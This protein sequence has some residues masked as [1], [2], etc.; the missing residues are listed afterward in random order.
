MMLVQAIYYS[1]RDINRRSSP[2]IFKTLKVHGSY[3]WLVLRLAGEFLPEDVVLKDRVNR[4]K[5]GYE[6]L[7]AFWNI[8]KKKESERV[9]SIPDRLNDVRVKIEKELSPEK[10]ILFGSKARGDFH[11]KSDID[12]AIETD[13]S[14]ELATITDAVDIIQLN[15][16]DKSFRDK[17]M[18]EGIEL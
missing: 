18:D 6:K 2:L 17:I 15:K 12:I 3:Y 16:I 10:M 11:T 8:L 7:D 5:P 9:L 1:N 13:K 4:Q 14:I